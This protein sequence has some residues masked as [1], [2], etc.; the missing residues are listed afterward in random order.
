MG[1][2]DDR[3]VKAPARPGF[4]L[5]VD[6]GVRGA[7]PFPFLSLMLYTSKASTTTSF[8][9]AVFKSLQRLAKTDHPRETQTWSTRHEGKSRD[10]AVHTLTPVLYLN[11]RLRYRT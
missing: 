1:K 3:T 10:T 4:I 6:G 9:M 7:I 11:F 2:V 8:L 5:G